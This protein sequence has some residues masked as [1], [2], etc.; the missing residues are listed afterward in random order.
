MATKGSL[1]SVHVEYQDLKEF[2]SE[3]K[4]PTYGAFL[5]GTDVHT[6]DIN[7]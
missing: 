2:L 4:L 3:N 1:T 6:L 7:K 5:D